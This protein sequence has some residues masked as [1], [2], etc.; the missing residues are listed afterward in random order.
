MKERRRLVTTRTRGCD[1]R[2]MENDGSE[3]VEQLELELMQLLETD[4]YNPEILPTLCKGLNSQIEHNWFSTEI[5]L[6]IIKLIQFYPETQDW[7][8]KEII[9]QVL[10]KVLL[11]LPRPELQVSFH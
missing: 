2:I 4:R 9:Q 3:T 1:K 10:L 7:N 11:N 6:G 8:Y 5:N